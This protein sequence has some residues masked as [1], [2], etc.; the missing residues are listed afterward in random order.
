MHVCIYACC[1]GVPE[2]RGI[3]GM[4]MWRSEVIVKRRILWFLPYLLKQ[5]LSLNQRIGS[6]LDILTSALWG[7]AHICLHS[8]EV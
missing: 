3:V 8:A 1:V 4:Y 7:S 2:G 6:W 5:G